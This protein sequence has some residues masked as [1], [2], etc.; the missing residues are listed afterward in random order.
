[1][2][3]DMVK[4]VVGYDGSAVAVK[5]VNKV[6][7][8]LRATLLVL[9]F[10]RFGFVFSSV[11]FLTKNQQ[12]QT[13]EFANGE[14]DE[15]LVLGLVE[16][17]P[18]HDW[19]FVDDTSA[20]EATVEKKNALVK[21]LEALKASFPAEKQAK[22]TV[23]VGIVDDVREG[24]LKEVEALQGNVLVVGSLG[25]SALARLALGSVSDYAVRNAHVPV[26][27]IPKDS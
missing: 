19:P 6:L 10:H 5:A 21:N 9:S 12:L 18:S 14:K 1:V 13:F 17:V 3:I 24:L 20:A 16:R 4:Y 26:L 15:V 11:S 2:R 7:K 22:T 8:L 25:T 27:V 23:V